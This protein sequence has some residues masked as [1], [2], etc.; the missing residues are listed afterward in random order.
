MKVLLII[1]D[2]NEEE[3]ILRT[4]ASIETF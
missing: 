4:I 1:P 3:N 2:Y